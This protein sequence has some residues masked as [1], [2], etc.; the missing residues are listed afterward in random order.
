MKPY[1]IA[2]CD[3]ESVFK[4]YLKDLL[5][6]HLGASRI[7]TFSSGEEMMECL[8]EQ[9]LHFDIVFLDIV[10]PNENNGIE[11]AKRLKKH[12]PLCQVIFVTGY[13]QYAVDVYETDHIYFILKDDLERRL[14]LALER[15]QKHLAELENDILTLTDEN[16][17]R[18][19]Q[20]E[21]LFI[22]R[23]NRRSYCHCQDGSVWETHMRLDDIE[24]QLNSA[25]WGRSHNSFLVNLR[26]IRELKKTDVILID[27]SD[28]PVSRAHS[29]SF[30]ISFSQYLGREL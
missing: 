28:I 27:N 15:A 9:K 14:P 5:T 23:N 21:I 12:L 22:E 29:A 7:L 4:T 13:L 2:I 19:S 24:K 26:Y 17:V 25:F 16:T 8:A 30:R 3:D 1:T 20:R 18:L 6:E 11:I 10:L